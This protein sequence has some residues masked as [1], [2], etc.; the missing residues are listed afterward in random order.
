MP[1]PIHKSFTIQR[2]YPASVARVFDAHS[3]PKKRRRWFAEGKGFTIDAYSLDFKVGGF[4]RC[5][6]RR[7]DGPP[8]TFDGVYLDVVANERIVLAYAMTIGGAPMSSSL[9]T[10]EFASSG[11][12]TLLRFTEH[13]VFVDGND[14]SEGRREGTVGLL[15]AL[16]QELETHG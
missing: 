4:E 10:I 5:H 2:R 1:A 8:L 11:P 16:A 6:F 13:S 7:G 9:A 3:D 12:E 15:E 14:G